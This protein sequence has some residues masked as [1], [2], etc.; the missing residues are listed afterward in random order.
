MATYQKKNGKWQ[1]QVKTRGTRKAKSFAL[2]RDA[3]EW[4]ARLELEAAPLASH[5]VTLGDIFNQY[6][7]E[8]SPNKKGARWEI[9]RLR[10]IAQDKF[11]S[12]KA[13]ELVPSDIADWRDRRLLEVQ[14][15]S[16]NREMTLISACLTLATNEWGLLKENPISK[17]RKPK[18]PRPRSR[19]ISEAELDK[20]RDYAQGRGLI[21]QQ[22]M[23]CVDFAIETAMRQGEIAKATW[24]NVD[25][26]T[27]VLHIPDSKS[28]LPRD[29]P[30]SKRA[31]AIIEA[32]DKSLPTVFGLSNSQISTAFSRMTKGC[33][34][35]NMVFHD[36]R[37]EA[38]TRLCKKIPVE[39]L[40]KMTGHRD[41][42]ILVNVYYNETAADM[43]S[44]LD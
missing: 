34:I 41:I 26:G 16:V 5:T 21:I 30:L 8:V 14:P 4:A 28:G 43:V 44:A 22:T 18:K 20:L 38:I 7:K 40:S 23:A 15:A 42:S 9:I 27:R 37:H 3:M 29:V 13:S 2:K 1:A 25:L 36:T 32:Q 12:I 39:R 35:D 6:A 19:L 10:K 33:G 11:A 24:D 31:T 17:V